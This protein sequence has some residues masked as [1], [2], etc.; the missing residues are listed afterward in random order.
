MLCTEVYSER[1]TGDTSSLGFVHY[2]RRDA[3]LASVFDFLPQEWNCSS[4]PVE[5]RFNDLT[6]SMLGAALIDAS[7]LIPHTLHNADVKRGGRR[8][9]Y[10]E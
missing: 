5:D 6:T 10:H 9:V 2:R 1:I 4:L 3:D 7:H 8:S